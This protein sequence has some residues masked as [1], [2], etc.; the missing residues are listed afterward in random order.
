[1]YYICTNQKGDMETKDAI[2]FRS[3]QRKSNQIEIRNEAKNIVAK[4]ELSPDVKR[5]L[6]LDIEMSLFNIEHTGWK[7]GFASAKEIYTK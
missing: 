2:N 3:E 1:M 6:S 4:F 7:N 5:L